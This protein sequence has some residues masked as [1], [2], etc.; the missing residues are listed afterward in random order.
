MPRLNILF[1]VSE[2]VPFAKTGGLADVAGAL[3][4][5][6]ADR[7]HDVRIVM[8]RYRVT[9]KHPARPLDQVLVVP[10]NGLDTYGGVLRAKLPR[11]PGEV[12]L[13]GT[14]PLPTATVYFLEHDHL[15]DRDG[16]YG[17]SNGDFGDNLARFT[18]LSRGALELCRLEGW[19]PDV[20]HVQDWP[21]SL[22]PVYLNTLYRD[23]P[24][25]QAASVLTVHNLA[26]QGW[27]GQR[28]LGVTGLSWDTYLRGGLERSGGI[29]LLQGGLVHATMV[30]TVSPRYASEIQTRDGGEGM[31]GLLRARGDVVG[32]LNGIDE[33]VWNPA[34]DK[35]LA[36]HY[37]VK[38]MSGKARCKAALQREMGLPERPD[39]PLIGLV[40]RLVKQKGID[41]FAEALDRLLAED[42]QV[43][44]LGSGESW[45]EGLFGRLS[46][47]TRHFRA[48]IGMNEPL[49]HRIE[50]GADLFVMPSRYEPCGLNQMYSQRYGTLPVVR[51]V[52]G[53][54]D[55]VDNHVTGFK[56]EELSASALAQCV[57]W[58]LH[59]YRHEPEHF[60]AMQQRAMRKP[61]GWAHASR[62]YE[63]MFRLA[64]SR[65]K[66]DLRR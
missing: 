50:A 26:Y 3:P 36:A 47:S 40:S 29:N 7:G 14:A 49:S 48:Y 66:A 28:D 19:T 56:F 34:T 37:S 25:G 21:T 20:V 13:P 4:A 18:F 6:L 8:P 55:T 38:D 22:V 16:V 64:M 63:A 33:D 17:D 10:V 52:G 62:Q 1:V 54:D 57:E 51:A 58:A 30:S 2:C 41:V 15:F 45:A 31:D 9:K 60:R 43:V 32:I 11:S 65:R 53:L 23:T 39:V 46:R 5:A 12:H 42:V 61:Q 59:V 35:H 44:V 27:F 24:L